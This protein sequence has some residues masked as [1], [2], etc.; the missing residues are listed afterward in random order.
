M[1]PIL[2]RLINY[3]QHSKLLI[4]LIT[5]ICLLACDNKLE[6]IQPSFE[7]QDEKQTGSTAD[8][9][10]ILKQFIDASISRHHADY[11]D[12]LSAKDRAIKTKEKYLEEQQQLQ[13]NLADAYFQE[14]T[15]EITSV[16]LNG[17]EATADVTYLYPDVERMIKQVYNLSILDK[18]T[19]PSLDEMKLQI[20]TAFKDKPLPKK[21]ITRHFTLLQENKDWRLYMAWDKQK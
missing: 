10:L 17:A 15:Y 16:T 1:T 9:E 2:N 21:T 4:I 3:M 6:Q 5:G 19:L 7:I 18:A 20:D 8:A 11:Y 12:L 14:I 13:P